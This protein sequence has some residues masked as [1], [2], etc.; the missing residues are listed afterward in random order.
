MLDM[1]R[2]T[3]AY[4]LQGLSTR[5][6]VGAFEDFAYALA[7]EHKFNGRKLK[8]GPLLNAIVL[9]FLE[10]PEEARASYAVKAL[11]HLEEFLAE[12]DNGA[13]K[14]VVSTNEVARTETVDGPGHRAKRK[15]SG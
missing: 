11:K 8:A 12:S 14:A 4:R 2:L 3:A 7:R 1:R 15:R 5:E 10:M 13:A 9:R 6:I